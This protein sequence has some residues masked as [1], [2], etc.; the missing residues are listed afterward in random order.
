MIADWPGTYYVDWADLKLAEM[1]LPQSLSARITGV[2][3]HTRL[4]MVSFQFLL[5][6][7]AGT[8]G[9]TTDMGL[10][11]QEPWGR[12][13]SKGEQQP[14]REQP[15]P[16]KCL[17]SHYFLPPFCFF[18]SDPIPRLTSPA[19]PL[20]SSSPAPLETSSAPA[21]SLAVSGRRTSANLKTLRRRSPYTGEAQDTSLCS[22]G[23]L[24][25]VC[26][27]L[28]DLLPP[29]SRMYHCA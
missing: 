24:L 1:L 6:V 15:G 2:T 10:F 21:M 11:Y 7:T 23:F 16:R 19:R 20:T 14:V 18:L 5:K 22:A 17:H 26:L 27:C 3:H 28:P 4:L 9:I 25:S 12:G 13:G 8:L 29:A